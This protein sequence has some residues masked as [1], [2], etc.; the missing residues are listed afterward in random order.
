MLVATFMWH[1]PYTIIY[2]L[3]SYNYLVSKIALLDD[4][5]IIILLCI[6]TPLDY[7]VLAASHIHVIGESNR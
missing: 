5:I 7:R 2:I 3:T 6:D 4:V 1:I